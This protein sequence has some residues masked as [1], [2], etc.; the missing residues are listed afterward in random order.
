MPSYWRLTTLD[1]FTG[2]DW[3][4]TN[5]YR[6]FSG[7]LPGA[8]AVPP[9]TRK[10]QQTFKVQALDS[11][12]LP[13]AFTPV[14]VYGVRHVSYDPVS[15]SLITSHPTSNGLTYTVESYQYLAD[16]SPAD[17][18]KAPPVVDHQ[19]PQTLRSAP[20]VGAG[21]CHRFGQADY[22]GADDRVRQS[23]GPAELLPGSQGS[24]TTPTPLTTDT[25]PPR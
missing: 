14:A 23:P 1:T 17:L 9:G 25:A 12:W 15:D 8:Q 20:Q 6:S 18:R 5:S 3:V 16:L 13:D 19:R 22:E 7:Q 4:S 24:P 21:G 2:Q 11:V 10:V